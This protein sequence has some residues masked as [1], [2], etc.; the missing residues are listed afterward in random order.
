MNIKSSSGGSLGTSGEVED[1]TSTQFPGLLD[2]PRGIWLGDSPFV[3]LILGDMV[4]FHRDLY[5]Q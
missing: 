4:N 5:F 3:V 1:W 2:S